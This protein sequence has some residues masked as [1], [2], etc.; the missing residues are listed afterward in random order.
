MIIVEDTRNQINKHKAKREWFNANGIKCIRSKLYCGDY[1]LL[2]DQSVCI[3]TK[4]DWLELASNICGKQH[5]RFR[6]E[7][8]R[9]QDAQIH[10]IVLVEEECSVLDWKSPKTRKGA[11]ISKVEPSI[12]AKAMRTM[13]K[14]YGVDFI[15]C[16]KNNAP[17][18]IFRILKGANYGKETND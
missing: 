7:C 14:K 11:Q 15:H 10:L 13:S 4:K 17:E 9:A 12:L 1:S 16:S 5:E 18:F 8:I 3:D 2:N 6:N